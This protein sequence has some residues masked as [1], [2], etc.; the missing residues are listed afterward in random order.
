MLSISLS[1]PTKF[2]GAVH[3]CRPSS[4]FIDSSTTFLLADIHTSLIYDPDFDRDNTDMATC[5]AHNDSSGSSSSVPAVS[6]L[7]LSSGDIAMLL[8]SPIPAI[9]VALINNYILCCPSGLFG[10]LK[11]LE[12]LTSA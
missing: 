2:N 8:T 12:I 10:E 6:I 5:A 9:L 11:N 4:V 1:T 7:S 3:A